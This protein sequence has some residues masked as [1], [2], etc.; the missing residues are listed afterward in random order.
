MA[1]PNSFRSRDGVE[2]SVAVA[3]SSASGD[4]TV[5]TVAAGDI[6]KL[7]GVSI[8]ADATLTGDIIIKLGSTQKT[9]KMRNA[10]VGGVHWMLPITG[11][12]IQGAL[13][14]DIVINNSVAEALSYAVYYRVVTP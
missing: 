9:V 7:Y 6:A 13:G 8:S 2:L 4:V 5:L 11:N 10:I 14:E 12:Y 3:D 1:S